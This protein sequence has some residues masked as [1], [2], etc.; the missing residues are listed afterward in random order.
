M[1]SFIS[2]VGWG[3]LTIGCFYLVYK[4][5]SFKNPKRDAEF[6]VGMK[7]AT[8]KRTSEQIFADILFLTKALDACK[9]ELVSIIEE[10]QLKLEHEN[11][12]PKAVPIVYNSEEI[13]CKFQGVDIPKYIKDENG[14][15]FEFESLAAY[16][17]LNRA[18]VDDVNRDYVTIRDEASNSAF[19]FRHIDQAPVLKEKLEQ[20]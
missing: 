6:L 17:N 19:F 13:A 7:N 8:G 12:T 3:I 1:E 18:I 11:P 15:W 16:D 20:A 9:Q 10:E 4:F 2:I 5:L 14:K